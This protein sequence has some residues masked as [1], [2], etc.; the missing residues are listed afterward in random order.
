MP[1]NISKLPH[2][3]TFKVFLKDQNCLQ[4]YKCWFRCNEIIKIREHE[5][6][7]SLY[8]RMDEEI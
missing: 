6:L 1:H 5:R 3:V 7:F 4:K 8:I 2:K